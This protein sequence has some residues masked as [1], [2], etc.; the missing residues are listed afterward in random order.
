MTTVNILIVDDHPVVRQGLTLLINQEPDLKV[1]GEAADANMALKAVKS[2]NP[3]MAIID[4][5]LEVGLSGLDLI[6]SI[7]ATSADIKMLTLSMHD[8]KL[9][10][11]RAL[12]A[13]ALGYIMKQESSENLIEAIRTVLGGNVYLSRNMAGEVL[14]NFASG[15]GKVGKSGAGLLTDR[16]LQVFQLIG[17]GLSTR[18]IA[19]QLH[20]SPKTVEA[21]R[22]NIK[23]KLGFDS[24]SKLMQYAVRWVQNV[25]LN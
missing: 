5:T 21:H 18:H 11:E 8:E 3:D 23:E 15:S 25:N 17:T 2:L 20:V 16:E 12:R 13:G 9:M 7:H 14:Q 4:L 1:C 10:A 6:K 24:A 22:A 19:E